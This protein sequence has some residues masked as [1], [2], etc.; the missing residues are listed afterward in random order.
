MRIIY[1]YNEI[2][3]RKKAHDIYIVNTCAALQNAGH[4]VTL[5][6]GRGSKPTHAHY[7]LDVPLH[8]LPLIRKNNPLNLSWN[9]PFFHLCQRYIKKEQPDWVITS[10][11]KQAS[12]HHNKK[13]PGVK[14]L[15]EVHE[16][17]HYPGHTSKDLALEKQMLEKADLITTTTRELKNILLSP[18]YSLKT[19]IEVVPLA[20]NAHPLPPPPLKPLTL[21]YIG[22]LYKGQGIEQLT[23]AM[24]TLPNIQLK[25]VGGTGPSAHNIEYLGFIPPKEL[26]P[27]AAQA[28]AFVA[29]FE[30]TGRMPYVAHTKLLEY[31]HWGRPI[32]APDITL[33][34]NHFPHGGTLLYK[35]GELHSALSSLENDATRLA[36][37]EQIT[38]YQDAFTWKKRATRYSELLSESLC[39]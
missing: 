36:L 21:M 8:T 25:I 23:H 30:L 18:P 27:I 34:R 7:G 2:L 4:T 39:F 33:V 29:P 1:P 24:R 11:R 10:V 32:I 31:A 9:R 3:P 16:L 35:P 15:Y 6:T 20:V 14:Y 37:Q 17:A 12:Y 22:Q 26:A 5:L 19:P 13:I 38:A 28:H